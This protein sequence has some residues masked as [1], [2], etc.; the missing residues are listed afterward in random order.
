[1]CPFN[2][3]KAKGKASELIICCDHCGAKTCRECLRKLRQ[4]SL[5]EV[6]RCK[7]LRVLA[8][9]ALEWLLAPHSSI[10][11]MFDLELNAEVLEKD[12]RGRVRFKHDC[13]FCWNM[14]LPVRAHTP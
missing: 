3:G 10:N 8:S 14:Q 7:H 2:K 12:S 4:R 1:M 9:G 6:A 11:H 5:Q 13:V